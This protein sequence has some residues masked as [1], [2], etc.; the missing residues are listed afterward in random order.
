MPLPF[1]EPGRDAQG[2]AFGA[3]PDLDSCARLQ[4]AFGL[5][6]A[7]F[8]VQDGNQARILEPTPRQH[9]LRIAGCS[10][11]RRFFAVR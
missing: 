1:D 3:H 10:A 6:H 8:P 9:N 4:T 5:D 2:H 11:P 7:A